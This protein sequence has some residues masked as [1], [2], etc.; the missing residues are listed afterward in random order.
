MLAIVHLQKPAI[1]NLASN[2]YSLGMQYCI[3]LH[4][5]KIAIVYLNKSQLLLIFLFNFCSLGMQYYS[6]N[7]ALFSIFKSQLLFIYK[8]QLLLI[9]LL[10]YI[11]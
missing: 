5:Q 1:V 11:P 8:S 9:L 6:M 3:I 4:F 10:I 2:L 7:T